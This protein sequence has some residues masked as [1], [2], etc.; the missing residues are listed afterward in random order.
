MN[1]LRLRPSSGVLKISSST[2]TMTTRKLTSST[3]DAAGS[4]GFLQCPLRVATLERSFHLGCGCTACWFKTAMVLHA[5]PALL[6]CSRVGVCLVNVYNPLRRLPTVYSW[7]FLILT[8]RVIKSVI[9]NQ[10]LSYKNPML[11]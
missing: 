10:V 3:K 4:V 1:D 8:P 11:M 9:L 7:Y 5:C 6:W 2:Q